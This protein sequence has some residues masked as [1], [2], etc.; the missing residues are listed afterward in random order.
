MITF[1]NAKINIGL[2][3]L[4]KRND[5]FHDL[6]TLFY[7]VQ[8]TDALEIVESEKL[9]FSTSGIEIPNDPK[10]NLCMRAYHLL[11]KD[12][13]LP[14]V[15]IHLHKVIPTGAG[16]GGGSADASFT[17][18]MLNEIFNLGIKNEILEKYAAQLGSDCPFFIQNK[19]QIGTGRGEILE[20]FEVNLKGR[21]I[22]LIYP[23]LNISTKEA[24]AKIKPKERNFL[25]KDTFKKEI[26]TWKNELENDFESALFPDYPLL[27]EIKNELYAKGAIF[28]GMSGSG[29]T[30]FG[31]FDK[32]PS[33]SFLSEYYIW[34]G[35]L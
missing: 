13:D 11:K 35:N 34:Q 20:S 14:P 3:I 26:Q 9:E 29:S 25:I 17:L 30:M 1:P 6:E 18:K 2:H 12:F 27:A 7:P 21:E 31:I 16:L 32:V 24:Y 23:N 33:F 8:W 19:P 15:H 4:R 5:N 28:A 10:E 22:V